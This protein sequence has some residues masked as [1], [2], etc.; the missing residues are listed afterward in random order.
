MAMIVEFEGSSSQVLVRASEDDFGLQPVGTVEAAVRKVKIT[1]ADAMGPLKEMADAVQSQV[2]RLVHPPSE[3][4]A[5]F[6]LELNASGLFVIANAGAK[7]TMTIQ[8]TW[9]LTTETE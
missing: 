4:V 9:K 2:E 5:E 6:G 3:V 8:L 7:A 1:L